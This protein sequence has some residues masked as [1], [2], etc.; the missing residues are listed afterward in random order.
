MRLAVHDL[1]CTEGDGKGYG[2]NKGEQIR[3]YALTSLEVELVP[4]GP[5]AKLLLQ[6]V[7]LKA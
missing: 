6:S 2:R 4:H 1:V 7:N 5:G 3:V